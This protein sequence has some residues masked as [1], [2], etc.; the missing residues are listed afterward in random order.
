MSVNTPIL[1]KILSE[2]VGL[3]QDVTHIKKDVAE[4][5]RDVAEMKRDV[6]EMKRDVA[7]M[8]MIISHPYYEYNQNTAPSL[9]FEEYNNKGLDQSF[10]ST[11][12]FEE[13]INSFPP[14][15][16]NSYKAY[17][18]YHLHKHPRKRRQK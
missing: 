11:K 16:I 13:Y 10:I 17:P 15:S 12:S 5:K 8:K 9:Y 2:L 6:A 7:E 1:Q 18:V 3:R 14:P 4:M